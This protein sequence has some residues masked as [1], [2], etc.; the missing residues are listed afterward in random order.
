MFANSQPLLTPGDGPIALVLAPTRELAV[1]I[2]Q[3]ATKFGSVGQFKSPLLLVA[4]VISTGPTLVFATPLSMVELRRGPKSAT[5]SAEWRLSSPP[6]V[7]LLTC[8]NPARLIFAVL[9]TSSWMKQTACLTW[10]SSLRFEKSFPRF[11]QIVRL[12]C[13]APR[14]LKTCR[15]WPRFVDGF[16]VL[17]HR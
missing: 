5:C 6:Q 15:S 11:V 12:S 13:L 7:V 2:Q 3:E 10:V 8:W 1:Q 4:Y 17:D 16:R 14:G 9:L